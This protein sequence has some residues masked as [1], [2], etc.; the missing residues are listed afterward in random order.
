MIT[1]VH[2][3]RPL[4]QLHP[5]ERG[6]WVGWL[7]SQGISPL[8]LVCPSE[9]LYDDNKNLLTVEVC[10]YD[11][12]GFYRETQKLTPTGS[13]LPFPAGYQTTR[14]GKM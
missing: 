10:G 1:M 4:R 12:Q 6:G 2:F 13:V 5:S 8:K 9:M 7:Y 11:K 14:K 3:D